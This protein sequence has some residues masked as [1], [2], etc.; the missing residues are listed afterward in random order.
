M[1]VQYKINNTA[2]GCNCKNCSSVK[3]AFNNY[4]FSNSFSKGYL[5]KY[6]S[7]VHSIKQGKI[8][9]EEIFEVIQ[10]MQIKHKIQF[11]LGLERLGKY[12]ES[13]KLPDI[14]P[15]KKTLKQYLTKLFTGITK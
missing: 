1:Q 12:L 4:G 13:R 2:F 14:P 7:D 10:N 5:A 9:P 11:I 3:E 8:K 15:P 6:T